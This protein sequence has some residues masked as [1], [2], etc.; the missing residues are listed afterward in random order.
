[1]CEHGF[2]DLREPPAP[3]PNAGPAYG[4][5]LLWELVDGAFGPACPACGPV[6]VRRPV[7]V[8]GEEPFRHHAEFPTVAVEGAQGERATARL[9]SGGG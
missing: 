4:Q 5:E 7:A 8:E 1:M 2:L 9:R 6:E 3:D